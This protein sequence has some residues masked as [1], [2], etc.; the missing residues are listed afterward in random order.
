[1]INYQAF[2]LQQDMQ[3]GTSKPLPLFRQ[4]TQSPAYFSIITRLRMVAIDRRRYINQQ[5]GSSFAQ[6]KAFPDMRDR[7]TLNLGR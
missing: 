2:P 3:P 6:P 5:T 7:Q 4:L 1:V